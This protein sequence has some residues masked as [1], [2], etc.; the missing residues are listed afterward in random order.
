MTLPG[1]LLLHQIA[2]GSFGLQSFLR[3]YCR[4]PAEEPMDHIDVS[5]AGLFLD[6]LVEDVELG[7]EVQ[8]IISRNGKPIARLVPFIGMTCTE[9]RIGAARADLNV[10]D[11]IDSLN[12][13]I[14]D[15]F[16]YGK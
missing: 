1:F 9:I 13:D 16:H 3:A 15:L 7:R 14:A 2:S 8:I 6:N 4:K 11:D 10:P 12:G 5:E